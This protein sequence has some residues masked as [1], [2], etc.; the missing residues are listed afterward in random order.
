M[1]ATLKQK[2]MTIA[3]NR[4]GTISPCTNRTMDECFTIENGELYF[5]FNS[6]DNSTHVVRE[7]KI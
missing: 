4:Y 7:S 3:Q 1:N 2:M 6:S 5:W